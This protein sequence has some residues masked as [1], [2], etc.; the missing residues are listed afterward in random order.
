L[1]TIGQAAITP[2]IRQAGILSR[3]A[4]LISLST[5]A[6]SRPPLTQRYLGDTNSGE[7]TIRPRDGTLKRIAFSG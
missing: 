3:A 2:E 7:T 6:C 1:Q 5:L 4:S